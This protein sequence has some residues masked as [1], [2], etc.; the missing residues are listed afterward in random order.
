MGDSDR[1]VRSSSGLWRPDGSMPDPAFRSSPSSHRL[2]I[3]PKDRAATFAELARADML[4][5]NFSSAETNFRLAVT[6]APTD[7]GLHLELKGAIAA[8]DAVRRGSPP[9]K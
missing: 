6:Y 9:K 3:A 5:G 1:Y 2:P 4:K 8:H 7:V